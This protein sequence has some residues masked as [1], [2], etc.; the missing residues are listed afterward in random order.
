VY[1]NKLIALSILIG[2]LSLSYIASFVFDPERMAVR[3]ASFQLLEEGKVAAVTRVEL[4]GAAERTALEKREGHWKVIRDGIAYPAKERRV[5]DLL[6]ALSSR[7]VY[8]RRSSTSAAH[9]ALGLTDAAA[10]RISV[11]G[12]AEKPLIDLLVGKPDAAGKSIALR[13]VG[14]DDSFSGLDRFSSYFSGG[15]RGWFDLALFASDPLTSESIQR[16]IVRAILPD[17]ENAP[18]ISASY[19]LSRDAESGWVLEGKNVKVDTAKADAYAKLL[20]QAEADDY[21]P[22]SDGIM[23]TVASIVIETGDGRSRKLEIGALRTGDQS[24]ATVSGSAYRFKLGDWNVERLIRS[25]SHFL[26]AP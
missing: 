16:I 17:R 8:P 14:S 20:A 9:A 15:N 12:T 3:S 23:K 11:Y 6:A 26:Q 21:S 25:E 5:D 22:A 4:S 7:A 18:G 13:F 10:S 2:V 1:R 24:D 19:T